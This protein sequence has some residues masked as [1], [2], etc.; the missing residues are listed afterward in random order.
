MAHLPSAMLASAIGAS[1]S[2]VAALQRSMGA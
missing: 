1:T 2:A